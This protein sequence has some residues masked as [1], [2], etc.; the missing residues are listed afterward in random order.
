[1]S[2]A[3]ST[4]SECTASWCHT[5]SWCGLTCAMDVLGN[6]WHPVVVHR[7]LANGPM[8]FGALADDIGTVTNKVLSET[9]TNLEADGIV[10]R[11]VIEE[12]PVRVQY[13]LTER[14]RDLNP[15]IEALQQWGDAHLDGRDGQL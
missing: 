4:D 6:K 9:L 7:L 2:D 11:T 14:G 3:Q 12:Q 13:S 8:G 15:A 10:E 5:E 1:M